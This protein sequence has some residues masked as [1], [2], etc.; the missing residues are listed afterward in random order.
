MI[1]QKKVLALV[2]I[3]TFISS[4]ALTCVIFFLSTSPVYADQNL[5]TWID[6]KGGSVTPSSVAAGRFKITSPTKLTDTK[7]NIKYTTANEGWT[8]GTTD[9]ARQRGWYYFWPSE[10]KIGD[11]CAGAVVANLDDR[12][13]NK[14]TVQLYLVGSEAAASGDQSCV[15]RNTNDY[16]GKGS[17]PHDD[18][19]YNISEDGKTEYADVINFVAHFSWVDAGRLKVNNDDREAIQISDGG[20]L[21]KIDDRLGD[22]FSSDHLI[23]STDDC[24]TNDNDTGLNAFVAFDKTGDKSRGTLYADEKGAFRS[25]W[26]GE[27]LDCIFSGNKAKNTAGYMAGGSISSSVAVASNPENFSKDS[28]ASEGT[29]DGSGSGSTEVNGCDG[30]AMDWIICPIVDGLANVSDF[31]VDNLLQPALRAQILALPGNGNTASQALYSVWKGFRNIADAALVLA[32]L[33]IIIST[34]VSSE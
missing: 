2:G 15:V 8:S 7:T 10:R 9:Y 23:Y 1:A 21:S 26:S 27:Q 18:Y 12:G 32:F 3:F 13:S 24:G 22:K 33:V 29:G 14:L 19:E 28:T 20:K 11:K 30:G 34:A 4:I 31:I 5:S 25:S 6:G 16:T 17:D